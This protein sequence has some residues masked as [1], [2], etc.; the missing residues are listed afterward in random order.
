[1]FVESPNVKGAV[2]ELAIELA[3]T[4]LGIP[5][6]KPVAEHGRYDMGF[7]VGPNI[8]RVQ[9]KWGNLNAATGVIQVNL[10]ST[11]Y[12]PRKSVRR[13]YTEDEID[14]LAVYCGGN[15]ECYLLPSALV[16]DRR[17][18]NLRLSPARNGQ[19]ACI[20]L[21]SDFE[22]R[23]AIAQLEERLRG[24]QEVAGS[25]PASSTPP[26]LCGIGVDEFRNRLG[27]Y[28][29]RAASGEEFFVTRRG[30]PYVRLTGA[31][32]QLSLVDSGRGRPRLAL[33]VYAHRIQAA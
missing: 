5:V 1:M 11:W 17:A 8:L 2:A 14:L 26:S 15:D 25:S 4:K 29:E 27:W 20:N 21:A 18:I 28:M 12:G 16:A 9:C 6:L 13:R 30:Q 24:T 32:P 19:R 7:E 23:G 3:A 31:A 22:F 33:G 10:T